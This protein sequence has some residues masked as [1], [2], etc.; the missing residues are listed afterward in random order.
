MKYLKYIFVILLPVLLL[1]GD[2][3]V[4]QSYRLGS[5]AYANLSLGDF[6]LDVAIVYQTRLL[7]GLFVGL[8]L[9]FFVFGGRSTPSS[10]KR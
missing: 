3:A 1:F 10:N 2:S 9:L 8:V 5:D 6:L 7:M 4:E